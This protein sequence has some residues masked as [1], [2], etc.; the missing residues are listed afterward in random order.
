MLSESSFRKTASGP[1]GLNNM[2]GNTGA[3]A[4]AA[5]AVVAMQCEWPNDNFGV[6]DE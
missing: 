4:A 5:A 1:V 3:A 6:T 2:N